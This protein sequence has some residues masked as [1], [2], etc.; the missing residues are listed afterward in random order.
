MVLLM[1]EKIYKIEWYNDGDYFYSSEK[2]FN[3]KKDAE[4][5]AQDNY[6]F[7]E[8]FIIGNP[9]ELTYDIVE[10]ELV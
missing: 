3:N 9:E 8:E 7:V 1:I 10:V 4:K 5:Y 2:F 6:S